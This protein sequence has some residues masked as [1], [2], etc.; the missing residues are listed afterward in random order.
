MTLCLLLTGCAGAESTMQP[1]LDLR[2]ALLDADGCTFSCTVTADFGET[3]YTF[4]ADCVCGAEQTRL[5]VTAPEEIA[6]I[7]AAVT[8]EE[9][10]LEF[11]DVVLELGTLAGGRLAPLAVPAVASA[12][13]RG[14]YIRSAG[15][16][17]GGTLV[18]YLRGYDEDEL[19]VHTHLSGDGVPT[20]VEIES[21][22]VRVADMT[23]SDF[24]YLT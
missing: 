22:G 1:A 10:T 7:G 8:G 21:M 4:S 13:W 2:S 12:C 11:D 15:N 3:V 9:A 5:T 19:T 6:G 14:E 23:I 17:N 24:T 16:E 18:T 20:R